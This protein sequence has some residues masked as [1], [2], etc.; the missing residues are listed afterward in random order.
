MLGNLSVLVSWSVFHH[1]GLIVFVFLMR[2]VGLLTVVGRLGLDRGIVILGTSVFL[3]RSSGTALAVS[4]KAATLTVV[5]VSAKAAALTVVITVKATFPVSV[6][7]TL[8]VI[9]T[10]KAATLTIVITVKA[11]LTVII[12]VKATLAVSVK[13]AL[14]VVIAA[15]TALTVLTI[16][17]RSYLLRCCVLSCLLRRSRSILRLRACCRL[18][19]SRSL[20]GILRTIYRCQLL[21]RCRAICL[22]L[23][24]ACS[25]GLL[26][27]A[28]L[29]VTYVG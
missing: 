27:H 13:A 25:Q 17:G 9:I 4:A 2:I 19:L 1:S 12:T 6:K 21:L 16:L 14:A 11:A 28:D 22:R 8:A 7:A 10:V 5:S 23:R 18:R 20:L 26:Y 3:T 29:R 15:H 24:S